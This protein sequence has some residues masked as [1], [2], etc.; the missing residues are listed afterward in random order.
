MAPP[1]RRRGSWR[2]VL[3]SVLLAL[4]AVLATAPARADDI[5]VGRAALEAAD[6]GFLLSADFEFDLSSRLEDALSKGVP[7]FFL[8]EFELTRPRWYWFDERAAT[9]SQTWRLSFHALT[10][11]YRLS[12]GTLTQS[13]GTLGEAL[14]TLQRIRSWLVMDRGQV[15]PDARYVA[16]VRMRLDTT[17]LPKPFQVSALANREW[18]LSSNWYR[19]EYTAPPE[20]PRA[21]PQPQPQPPGTEAV[22]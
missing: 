11:T 17:Q 22:R 14:R 7:L 2:V 6:E 19:W 16:G 12:S 13:F 9:A 3:A 5:L 4:A 10:R 18:T 8:V 1:R 15:Q 20:P 21:P